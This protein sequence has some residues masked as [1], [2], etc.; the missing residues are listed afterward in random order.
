V[1]A[2]STPRAVLLMARAPRPRTVRRALEPLLG[3]ESCA[4]LQAALISRAA[5]WAAEVAPGAVFIGYEPV[6]A[7]AEM[8]ALLGPE[9]SL[10]PQHGEGI[11]GRLAQATARLFTRGH[12]PVLI[13]WPDLAQWR[14]S[15]GTGAIA[16]LADGADL[17][18]GPQYDGGFYMVGIARPLAALFALPETVWRSPDAMSAVI[19]AA[20]EARLEVGLLRAERGLRR[21]ED[22]RA[23]LAD[24]LTDPEIRAIL[25]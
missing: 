19:A 17:A 23:A 22:V 13:I 24:P 21:P 18:L 5:Q 9:V 20:R 14:V 16:D 12:G 2:P 11:S 8:R 10:L 4:A 15:H 1:T 7:E 6:D 25:S 3:P